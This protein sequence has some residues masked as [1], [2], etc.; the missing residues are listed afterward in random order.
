M[1]RE[2][3][4]AL[5]LTGLPGVG[6]TT[7]MRR[8]ASALAGRR[9]QGFTTEEIRSEKCR[10]GF[11]IESLSGARATLAHVS[12]RS[13]YRVGRYRVDVE[14]LDRIVRASLRLDEETEVYLIDEIGKME[15]FSA[16]FVGA[17]AALLDAGRPLV[18]TIALHGGGPIAAFKVRPDVE[19]WAVTHENRDELP[20]RILGWLAG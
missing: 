5:L 1:K 6:K 18:A 20:S 7:V 17:V 15:C 13:S 8:L 3:P 16:K 4:Q 14:A 2:K 10:Q 9:I 11:R 19:T 12:I